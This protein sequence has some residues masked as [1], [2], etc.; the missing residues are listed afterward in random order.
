M[1]SSQ[2]VAYN[3]FSNNL[4]N[5]ERHPN[6]FPENKLIVHWSSQVL[7]SHNS[8]YSLWKEGIP[9]SLKVESMAEIGSITYIIKEL[10]ERGDSFDIGSPKYLLDLFLLF[11]NLP[12]GMK[13]G[14]HSNY[15]FSHYF[16]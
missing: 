15:H 5:E 16:L 14:F 2:D 11:P 9:V 6:N 3:C 1:P 8:S 12:P 13:T 10:Q 7:A 4:W